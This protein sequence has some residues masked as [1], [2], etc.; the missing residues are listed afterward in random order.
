M[1]RQQGEWGRRLAENKEACKAVAGVGHML[2]PCHAHACHGLNG[3]LHGVCNN[4][5]AQAG[6]KSRRKATRG[7]AHAGGGKVVV[8]VCVQVGRPC[9]RHMEEKREK[10]QGWRRRTDSHCHQAPSPACSQSLSPSSHPLLLSLLLLLPIECPHCL[11]C[12]PACLPCLLSLPVSCHSSSSSVCKKSACLSYT[13]KMPHVHEND[14]LRCQEEA[15][16]TYRMKHL[17]SHFSRHKQAGMSSR[18]YQRARRHGS[19]D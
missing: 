10:A 14:C 15:T 12:L 19:S 13:K 9:M 2:L 18:K 17:K 11:H 4:T 7:T 8:G 6:E 16:Q 3:A 5:T 1:Y